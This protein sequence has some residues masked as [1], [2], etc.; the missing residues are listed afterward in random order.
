MLGEGY[1]SRRAKLE[2]VYTEGPVVILGPSLIGQKTI[3]GIG[4]IIG[5][6]VRA[7]LLGLREKGLNLEALDEASKGTS[8]GRKCILRSFT[9]VYEDVKI[10]DNVETGHHVLIRE[11]SLIGAGTR[12]GS[13]TVVDGRVIIGRNVSIQTGV[14]LPPLTVIEDE[15]F[16]G[17]YVRVTNDK[18][19]PSSRM[20]GVTVRR[21]AVI[22]CGAVLLA[23]IEVGERAVVAAGAVVTKDVDPEIVVAGV[24][25]RPI[26]T[27]EEYDEKRREWEG[28]G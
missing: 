26:S 23:G 8:I 24:P 27:R 17:P 13:H 10:E 1:I 16:L 19:P 18:Y 9:V 7:K 22:G 21:G 20:R 2:D 6:P 5:Y 4:C 15:V 28:R 25:A 12:I 14:Y 3:L 11:K